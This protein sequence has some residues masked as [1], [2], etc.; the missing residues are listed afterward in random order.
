M[1]LLYRRYKMSTNNSNTFLSRIASIFST[2]NS[3]SR[4]SPK[5]S[6]GSSYIAVLLL[7]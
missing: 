6:S 4:Q 1:V 7:H 5:R 2:T 3:L